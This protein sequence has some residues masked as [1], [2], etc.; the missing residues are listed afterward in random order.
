MVEQIRARDIKAQ[1]GRRSLCP[2][3]SLLN[4]LA[5]AA[6][7]VLLWQGQ[8]FATHAMGG[9][10]SY[11]CLGGNQYLVTLNFYRDCNGI[12]APTN[13]NNGLQFR[14]RSANC[15][16]N[17]TQC[18]A[19][20]PT[21]ELIT[22][23]CPTEPDRCTSSSGTYGVQRYTYTRVVNLSA[24][25]ACGGTD[26]TFSW[27]L[28]CRNNAITSLNNPG[29]R[30]LYL[31]AQLNNSTG[32]CNNSPV[33]TNSPTAFYC[34]G[35]PIS[36]NPGAVDSDGDSLVY[37]LIGA[38]T[39]NGANIPYNNNYS[40]QQPIRNMG[41]AN[42]VVLD[43]QTGT[44][45]VTPSV[46]QVAVVTYQVREFRNGVFI[47]SV[48]RDVQFVIRACTGNASPTLSGI[49]GTSV[50]SMQVCAGT[51]VSFTVNSNDANA[52]QTVSMNWNS[53][54]PGATFTTSGSPFPS[55]TFTWTPTVANIG[56][57]TFTVHVE[58]DGCPLK[59]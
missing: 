36:Y 52:G 56:N 28:C 53:G 25:A 50:Y 45:T 16:A 58:D 47:G 20:N 34:L 1:H 24:Y 2:F 33:F 18:F 40:A 31:D 17:F 57:N 9:E 42:A 22:P 7:A 5:L 23:I 46:L 41:G 48:T 29:N 4:K 54:I 21:V 19:G 11:T 51:P 59:A 37:A 3:R 12:A 6:I 32:I 10:L 13:C 14:V 49:N 44:M 26:W 35:E 38:R 30:E 15:G 8:A 39:A 55:G 43:P 27:S